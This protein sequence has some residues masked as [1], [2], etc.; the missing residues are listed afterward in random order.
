M[1]SN[2]IYNIISLTVVLLVGSLSTAYADVRGFYAG[3]GFG[4]YNIKDGNLDNNDRVLKALV[5]YQ[6]LNFIGIEGSW[7][8]FNRVSNGNDRFEADGVGVAAVVTFPF[9][10]FVKGGQFWWDSDAVLSNT[11]RSNDGID[12]L[13]GVGYKLG[14][15][16]HLALRL[17]AERYDVNSIHLYT[18]TAGIDYKF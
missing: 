4:S 13:W 11:Q 3:A 2:K 5:G 8:D 17:E 1:N 16:E 6:F 9:G 18:Y 14:F 12:P 7:T 15:T 10:I